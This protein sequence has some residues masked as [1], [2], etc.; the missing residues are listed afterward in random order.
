MSNISVRDHL[1]Q[2]AAAIK[3]QIAQLQ[4]ELEAVTELITEDDENG[5]G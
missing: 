5:K 2:R 1:Q 3:T 4:D